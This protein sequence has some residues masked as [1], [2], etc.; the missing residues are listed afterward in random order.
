VAALQQY[1]AAIPLLLESE[2]HRFAD[3]PNQLVPKFGAGVYTI[4]HV[5]GHFI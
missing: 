1:D 5:D 2:L 4:W 3:W